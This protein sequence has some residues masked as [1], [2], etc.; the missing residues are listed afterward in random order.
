MVQVGTC[1]SPVV[2]KAHSISMVDRIGRGRRW[3]LVMVR[4]LG[5]DGAVWNARIA[6]LDGKVNCLVG[7]TVLVYS[8]ASPLLRSTAFLNRTVKSLVLLQKPRVA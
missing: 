5:S 2:V 3:K 4:G 6:E 7:H 1:S 8:A